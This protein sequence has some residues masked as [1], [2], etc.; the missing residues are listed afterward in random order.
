MTSARS[1][2]GRAAAGSPASVRWTPRLMRLVA[3]S[4]WAGPSTL[5]L[6]ATARSANSRLLLVRSPWTN[7]ARRDPSRS[8]T[9]A[10][11]RTSR[12]LVLSTR[13]NSARATFSASMPL[14]RS[15]RS[16]IVRRESANPGIGEVLWTTAVCAR[17]D[18][19]SRYM[20]RRR[21]P[22]DASARHEGD[23]EAD[24]AHQFNLTPSWISRGGLV[25]VTWP[26]PP[27]GS[28]QVVVP[29][30]NRV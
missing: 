20:P 2:N 1:S 17:E 13:A 10:T 5:S 12:P 28:S 30:Q 29:K 25:L 21:E 11:S 18:G 7:V 19:G 14:P 4:G 26:N 15:R 27:S 3:S 9:S 24:G 23:V 22:D 6:I 8:R 16:V